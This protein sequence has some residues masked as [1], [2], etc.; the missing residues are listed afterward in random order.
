MIFLKAGEMIM[1]EGHIAPTLRCSQAYIRYAMTGELNKQKT[2]GHTVGRKCVCGL[3]RNY[4]E[5][6]F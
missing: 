5:R 6:Y 4:L 1:F 2:W 3:L